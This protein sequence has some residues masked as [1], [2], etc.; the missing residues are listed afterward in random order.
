MGHPAWS[1]ALVLAIR[2]TLK[3]THKLGTLVSF[4]FCYGIEI[5]QDKQCTYNVTSRLVR[6][7]TVAVEKQ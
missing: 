6:V 5:K 4:I 1:F 2:S 3:K 7:T